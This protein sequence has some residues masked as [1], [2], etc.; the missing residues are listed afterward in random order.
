MSCHD[1]TPGLS[2]VAVSRVKTVDRI[3]F[4]APFNRRSICGQV[5]SARDA[6][7]FDAVWHQGR[8]LPADA[9]EVDWLEVS[10]PDMDASWVA[11]FGR[12]TQTHG[13]STLQHYF[14]YWER[15]GFGG[16]NMASVHGAFYD[17]QGPLN[18]ILPV[19]AQ[20]LLGTARGFG[21]FVVS[22]YW[23][24]RS[25]GHFL[26]YLSTQVLS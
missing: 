15:F 25:D 8:H 3:I 26:V 4:D 5:T 20:L 16:I 1:F 9:D 23:A 6:R 18:S 11:S 22:H 24:G 17:Y 10:G 21:A 2:Y 13:R 19:F 12:A 7:G 14:Q